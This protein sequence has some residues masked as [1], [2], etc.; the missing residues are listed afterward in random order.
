MNQ[1]SPLAP[2][3]RDEAPTVL[4]SVRGYRA[5]ILRD[6]QLG[7]IVFD[8]VALPP[9]QRIHRAECRGQV[10][11]IWEDFWIPDCYSKPHTAPASECMCG[12]YA[13]Y[14]E[15]SIGCI[16]AMA[17][18]KLFTSL[19]L[20]PPRW[21]LGSVQMSGKVFLGALGVMRAEIMRLEA[22]YLSYG[23]HNWRNLFGLTA[24]WKLYREQQA[25]LQR[26]GDG[27]GVP[28]FTSLKKLKQQFPLLP[29][30]VPVSLELK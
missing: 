24:P 23:A 30:S 1:Q 14:E 28:V 22:L 25:T 21:V 27:Y 7:S 4:G 8:Q 11:Q 6:G 26:L 2:E 5:W 13:M 15:E 19:R 9:I 18:T 12:F 17:Q 29:T 10:R 20:G 16:S 3:D